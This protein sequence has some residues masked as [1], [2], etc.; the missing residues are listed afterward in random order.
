MDYEYGFMTGF[1]PDQLKRIR[2][3]LQHAYFIPGEGS[4]REPVARTA[5]Q[6]RRFIGKPVC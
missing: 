3:T 4:K 1:T 2:Y 5:G 6:S